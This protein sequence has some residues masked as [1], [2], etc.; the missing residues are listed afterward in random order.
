MTGHEITS[1]PT[2]A[3]QA[4]GTQALSKLISVAAA[5]LDSDTATAR[6]CLERAAELLSVAN[7]G[8]LSPTHT[9]SRG[10]LAPWQQ[11]KVTAY[12]ATNIASTIRVSDLAR[13]AGLRHRHFFRAFRESFGETPLSHVAKQRVQHAQSLMLSSSAPLSQ[14]ALD[15]G[16]CDQ[17]HFTR[18]FRRTVGVNPSAWRR[19]FRTGDAKAD[20]GA[21]Q[22][23]AP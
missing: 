8:R 7:G 11:R 18:V 5:T 21:E 4:I 3:M 22:S 19:E 15:C 10:G 20:L 6:A 13:V 9:A 16:M 17:A 1:K 2:V 23:P 12:V 14:I